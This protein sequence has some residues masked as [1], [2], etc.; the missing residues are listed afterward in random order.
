MRPSSELM[1]NSNMFLTWGPIVISMVAAFFAYKANS[2]NQELAKESFKNSLVD[3][4]KSAKYM[5]LK[6][7]VKEYEHREKMLLIESINDHLL[8][9]QYSKN[10]D[11]YMTSE[12]LYKLSLLQE[13]VEDSLAIFLS[14]TDGE[15]NRNM[16]IN[17]IKN[18]LSEL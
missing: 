5:I 17:S 16:A 14:G 9:Q 15:E 6:L 11:K 4:L 13:N 8:Y 3:K 10:K 18:Y 7:D 1:E 12:E 2:I